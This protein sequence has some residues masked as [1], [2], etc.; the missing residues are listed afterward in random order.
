MSHNPIASELNMDF[1]STLWSAV[2][3][4]ERL[5][6][7]LVENTWQDFVQ[8]VLKKAI[9]ISQRVTREGYF[10]QKMDHGVNIRMAESSESWRNTMNSLQKPL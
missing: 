1:Q 3:S 4:A 2:Q 10:G 6:S 9:E 8:K 7:A 5:M